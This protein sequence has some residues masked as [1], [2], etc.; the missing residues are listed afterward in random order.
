[1]HITEVAVQRPV[2]TTVFFIAMV[3]LGVYSFHRLSVDFLPSISVPNLLV[4]TECPGLNAQ[5][6]EK[7]VTEWI[8]SAL[9]TVQDVNRIE[10]VSR[11]GLSLIH[12]D[13]GWGSNMNIAFINVRN[14][15]DRI[16][17]NLPEFVE[18]SVILSFDPSST[19]IMTLVVTGDRV[20]NPTTAKSYE[21]AL[22]ELK[23]VSETV[24]KRRLEQLDGV[25]YALVSGGLEREIQVILD[26]EK[27][28]TYQIGF[29]EVEQAL[30]Q[31]N[32]QSLGGTIRDRHY[33]FP[34]RIEASY[35]KV[36][37]IYKTPI[38]STLREQT[39]RLQDIARIED[40]YKKRTGYVRLN[41]KEV[42]TLF[43]FKEAGANT[44][45]T[46]KKIYEDL[47]RLAEEYPEFQVTVAFDQAEFIQESI[48]NVLHALYLGSIV[49]FFVLFFFLQDLRSLVIVGLAIPIS[50]V[51]T[52]VFMYFLSINLNII[53]L[54]G[55]ALG[56]G[57][58]V[59]NSIVVLENIYRYREIGYPTR[60]AAVEGA[61]EVSMAI[62]ASTLT[63]L[64]V[65]IPLVYVKGLAGELFYNQSIVIA[66]S[67]A[68]SL[69][70]SLTFLPVL[71]IQISR[72][73]A[74]PFTYWSMRS[75]LPLPLRLQGR[76]LPSK[77]GTLIG[78]VLENAVYTAIYGLY[79][80][81][82]IYFFRLVEVLIASFQRLFAAF[83]RTY[84]LIL[85]TVLQYK[86][87]SIFT[88]LLV[89]YASLEIMQQL[90]KELMPLVDR[91][92]LVVSAELPMGTNLH[93]TSLK[94]AHLES[95]L[96]QQQK[97][98]AVLSSVGITSDVLD[99]RYHP[100]LNKAILDIEI[101]QE[102]NIF[103]VSHSLK[104]I[105]AD[106][107][108]IK[109]EIKRRESVFE[110]LF[111]QRPDVF[112]IELVGPELEV[113]DSLSRQIVDFMRQSDGFENAVSNLKIAEREYRLEIKRS[114]LIRYGIE[115][116]E[117]VAFLKQRIKG[118]IPTQFI[119]FSDKIDIR[120]LADDRT[121]IELYDLL[122]LQ[123]PVQKIDETSYVPLTDLV[124]L[125]PQAGF[126]AI[127][128]RD[129]NRTVLITAILN[130]L[131]FSEATAHLENYLRTMQIPSGY[132]FEI[133]T[134][135]GNTR[136]EFENLLL[137]LV[138]S[139]ALIYFILSAQFESIRVPLIILMAIPLS[140]VGVVFTL[141]VSGNTL[142]VMSLLGGIVLVGIVVNDAIVKVDFIHRHYV[143]SGDVKA[144]IVEAGRKRFRPIWMTTA[145][146]VCG[147]LPM[148]L[149]MGSGDELRRPLAWTIIGGLSAATFLTLIVIP[150]IYAGMIGPGRQQSK[151]NSN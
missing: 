85:S 66:I 13:F 130:G 19:P 65:F 89:F 120:L 34:L 44:V 21:N 78:W 135:R 58:L 141:W 51:T 127:H 7:N 121:E 126:E 50:I 69:L 139:I 144:A 57:I 88:V 22:A 106:F 123:F 56:I 6:I 17:E 97:I 101:V 5:D 45:K 75:Y 111:Q 112:D 149:A 53:S 60:R 128:R 92:K 104:E 52:L 77:V 146:T 129:Q 145:T 27:M 138:I 48:V 142:N 124:T 24:I 118:S 114:V 67:L 32:V 23:E 94:V 47:Y 117:L 40:S 8:E 3:M 100:S 109:L 90:D 36:D 102:A 12:V 93:N 41:G 99:R 151:V 84:E 70:V 105:F 98:K 4:R 143:E 42:I 26:S 54:G 134:F 83:F 9:S 150:T 16:Q 125:E 20:E 25:A 74:N 136:A 14:R 119:D 91:K 55:L 108:D 137:I 86:A 96:L 72:S 71:V 131:D 122:K 11:D 63:T 35:N 73:S 133:G 113:L 46:S 28:L 68:V 10:S 30:K 31:F 76:S 62:T 1:M 38:R 81:A 18:R 80:G 107:T 39:I 79:K 29:A 82:L 33:Q 95:K 61:K 2:A 64:S 103:E 43:L 59:D 115:I 49:T 87:V 37:E 15:L 148:A 140:L 110:Q 116:S 147:L 132:W